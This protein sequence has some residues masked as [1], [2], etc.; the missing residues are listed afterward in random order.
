MSKLKLFRRIGESM[1]QTMHA[2]IIGSD[3]VAFTFFDKLATEMYPSSANTRSW[4]ESNMQL[5]YDQEKE[6]IQIMKA[7]QGKD[8]GQQMIDAIRARQEAKDHK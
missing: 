6:R 8:I 4:A 5:F 3:D 7:L 1:A 2:D